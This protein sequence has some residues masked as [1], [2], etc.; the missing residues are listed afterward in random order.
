MDSIL[1]KALDWYKDFDTNPKYTKRRIVCACNKFQNK[2][3]GEITFVACVR[4]Y[5]K[6]AHMHVKFLRASGYKEI[7]QGFLDQFSDFHSREDAL[8]IAL[9]MG[10]ITREK[11]SPEDELFS[12]D[13]Y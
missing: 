3:T 13:L 12:E 10:Q 2:E 1:F 7:E 4:H 9:H 5:S 6:E 8:R 11:C